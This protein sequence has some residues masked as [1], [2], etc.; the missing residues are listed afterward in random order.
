MRGCQLFC[1]DLEA[2]SHR[3][4]LPLN[5][6]VT[7]RAFCGCAR[8]WASSS[9]R[10]TGQE[11]LFVLFL[12]NAG[13]IL[14]IAQAR[15]GLTDLHRLSLFACAFGALTRFECF[16]IFF[17]FTPR[18]CFWGQAAC[19]AGPPHGTLHKRTGLG[20]FFVVRW[21]DSKSCLGWARGTSSGSVKKNYENSG[22]SGDAVKG[23]AGFRSRRVLPCTGVP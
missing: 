7:E 21:A 3:N 17:F 19:A 6:H 2:L 22:C 11:P 13:L 1:L 20:S 23:T 8:F 9:A 14:A 4:S 18:R 5:R 15:A 16:D 10:S 12:D